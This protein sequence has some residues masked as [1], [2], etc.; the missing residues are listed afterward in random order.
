MTTFGSITAQIDDGDPPGAWPVWLWPTDA[1]EDGIFL[2]WDEA[3]RFG[4]WLQGAAE[5]RRSLGDPGGEE[6]A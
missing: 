6:S 1:P 4:A 2:S 5:A 3:A